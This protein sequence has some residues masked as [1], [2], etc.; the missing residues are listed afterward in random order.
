[1]RS[2]DLAIHRR[3]V[4]IEVDVNRIDELLA[5][6]TV[7]AIEQ[8]V[9]A[10]LCTRI[11]ADFGARVIKIEDPNG[12][13]FARAY[14]NVVDGLSAH[15]VWLS[16]G[17]ESVTLNLKDAAGVALVH[18]L[19]DRADALISNLAPGTMSR[20]GLGEAVIRA[21]HPHV[22]SLEISGYGIGGPLERKRAYD[23]LIQAESGACAIT[24]RPGAPAKSGPPMAD[25][26][27]GL[28]AVATVLAALHARGRTDEGGSASI[29]MFDVMAEMMASSLNYTR[30][31]GQNQVP[32]GMGSPAVAPYGAFR[33][34]DHQTVVLGT[35]N[36]AEW[37]RLTTMVGRPDL[38]SHPSYLTNSGRVRSRETIEAII[39]EWCAA[40]TLGQIQNAADEAGIGNAR[41]NT[42]LEVLQHEQLA[43][44][45]RWQPVATPVGPVLATLPP[46]VAD[47][48]DAVMG[49]VPALGEHTDAV[50]AELGR[51]PEHIRRL[52]HARTI[53]N[54]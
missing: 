33:T 24:G 18:E 17:K 23:L 19:L 4:R 41:Y 5:G 34:A 6:V 44:R 32:V 7:V 10:P 8:A 52:R 47:S 26:C 36:D 13:D 37:I 20:L 3:A 9:A 43:A 48:D 39:G 15:F 51:S 46:A 12:G 25:V 2:S 49:A 30:Y 35:T 27:T 31:T 11:L 53:G 42:P 21:R 50:L 40:R 38:A 1:M 22:I 16:R 29:S 45:R 28:Y 14:D 54:R